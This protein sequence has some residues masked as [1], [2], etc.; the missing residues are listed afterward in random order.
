MCDAHSGIAV[1]GGRVKRFRTLRRGMCAIRVHVSEVG[2]GWAAGTK[3]QPASGDDAMNDNEGNGGGMTHRRSWRGMVVAAW[4]V[5]GLVGPARAQTPTT[6]PAGGAAATASAQVSSAVQN[7]IDGATADLTGRAFAQAKEKLDI[8]VRDHA[9]ELA[10]GMLL[11]V[12][13]SLGYA[14]EQLATEARNDKLDANAARRAETLVD[15]AARA[16][17]QM[18]NVASGI[19]DYASAEQAYTRV[20]SYRPNLVDALLGIARVYAAVNKPLPAIERF[21]DYLKSANGPQPAVQLELGRVY[22]AAGYWNQAIK[23]LEQAD[24]SA[25]ASYLMAEAYLGMNRPD[26]VEQAM[27]L[28]QEAIRKAPDRAEYQN[29][30]ASILLGQGASA[31]A[32]QII[33]QTIAQSRQALASRPDDEDLLRAMKQSY[34]TF[35]RILMT[36][37]SQKPDDLDT[38][39]ELVQAMRDQSDVNQLLAMHDALR[40][41]GQAPVP[42]STAD[43]LRLLTALLNLQRGVGD[44]N[45][46]ATA[47]RILALD[48]NHAAAKAIVAA[49]QP[50]G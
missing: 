34:Q 3:R 8:L 6:A 48:P 32:R 4:A 30:L 25:E 43:Q 45:L 17:L 29:R 20:L 12:Y 2:D 11:S 10:P 16:Y 9:T 44:R 42:A 19:G 35:I 46:V 21:E 27:T 1:R 41:L 7:L 5:M 14:N 26:K 18:G 28:L 22:L 24:N 13:S 23:A 36:A 38:R 33:T 50:A 37:V 49:S 31:Q 40:V 47:Q 39:M 15:E